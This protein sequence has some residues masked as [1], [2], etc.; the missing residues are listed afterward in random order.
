[1]NKKILLILPVIAIIGCC[2]FAVTGKAAD[3]TDK[4]IIASNFRWRHYTSNDGI[5][6][7]QNT[8]FPELFPVGTPKSYVDKILSE[9]GGADIIDQTNDAFG[10]YAYK[11]KPL[12]MMLTPDSLFAIVY[13]DKNAM[14]ESI[15]F[16]GKNV[17]GPKNYKPTP[18]PTTRGQP[19]AYHSLK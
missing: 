13:Y 11:Y 3:P 4:N 18:V 17:V 8:V 16:A 12:N 5:H 9:Q 2:F 6:E 14:V 19:N 15:W 1:M 10:A 7:L